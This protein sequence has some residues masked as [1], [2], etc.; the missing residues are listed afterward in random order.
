[1]QRVAFLCYHTCP[2]AQLGEK[3]AG[4][5]NVYVRNLSG[6]LSKLGLEIDVFSRVHDES[7]TMEDCMLGNARLI[8]INAGPSNSTKDQLHQYI[9]EFS[10][11]IQRFADTNQLKYDV[12]HSHYWLSANVGL[13]LSEKWN[14]PHVTT[15]H[16]LEM[17]KRMARN[18]EHAM[19]FR[20]ESE[21]RIIRSDVKIIASHSHERDF[22]TH[23]YEASPNQVE[24]IPCGVDKRLFKP[25]DKSKARKALE[26]TRPFMLLSVGRMD[27]GK[28]VDLL[29]EA[30]KLMDRSKDIEIFIVG[31]NSVYQP[32]VQRLKDLTNRLGLTDQ[33]RFVGVVPQKNLHLYY[34]AADALVMPS[35]SE[36]F[37]LTALEAMA[38]GTPVVASRVGGLPA[39]V[40]DGVSGYL[41][42]WHRPTSFAEKIEIILANPSLAEEM[43]KSA[44][45]L[46]EGRSWEKMAKKVI[47]VYETAFENRSITHKRRVYEKN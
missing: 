9:P 41:V 34:N 46:S 36:S 43:G 10:E 13:T 11:N 7:R 42:P 40:K 4:G 21:E 3:D 8:H 26:M 44:V 45:I 39:L 33:V 38:C 14:L 2:T 16:T 20:E 19:T 23:Y 12:I 22:L 37:G 30:V 5:M 27:P 15:F 18:G 6:A 32:E 1:M 31:D 25:V 35:Y 29:L 17:I 24:I 28:G 47:D